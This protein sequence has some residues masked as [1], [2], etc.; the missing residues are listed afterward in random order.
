MMMIL[1]F[2]AGLVL[3]TIIFSGGPREQ[4]K[5]TQPASAAPVAAPPGVPAGQMVGLGD[6][7][8]VY[9]SSEDRFFL[10]RMDQGKLRVVDVY[11]LQRKHAGYHGGAA[12]ESR[13]GWSFESLSREAEAVVEAKGNQFEKAVASQDWEK[14][15]S[16]AQEIAA[17]GGADFL[18]TWLEPKR[19]WGGRRAAALALGER[20]SAEAVPVLADMLLE[21]PR[22]RERALKLL[23]KLTGKNFLEGKGSPSEESA[24]SEYK[25]WYREHRE[26]ED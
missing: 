17:S 3:V 8:F 7:Y 10:C 25:K 24:I 19:D 26:Q 6:G 4:P 12:K 21:G 18:K 16:L 5:E 15:E 14:A 2:F 11:S 20:R 22:V 9:H 13:H 23:V 1:A